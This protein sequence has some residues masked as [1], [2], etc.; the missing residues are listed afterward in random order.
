MITSKYITFKDYLLLPVLFVLLMVLRFSLLVVSLPVLRKCGYGSNLKE[1]AVMAYGGLR[2]AV[3]LCLA[4]LV[5]E[6]P[7]IHEEI[8]DIIIFHTGGIALLTLIVNA[9]TI[10]Y[11]VNW[12]GMSRMSVELMDI[13]DGMVEHM[14]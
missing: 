8:K 4:L 13:M 7:L 2:G 1:V 12:L 6:N 9:M 11:L 10:K 14:D 3:G 5:K